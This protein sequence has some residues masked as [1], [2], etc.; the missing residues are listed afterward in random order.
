MGDWMQMVSDIDDIFNFRQLCGLMSICPAIANHHP[1]AASVGPH[2]S[3]DVVSDVESD[4]PVRPAARRRRRASTPPE[5]D[6]AIGTEAEY[7]PPTLPAPPA[8]RRA[9]GRAPSRVPQTVVAEAADVGAAKK[10]KRGGKRK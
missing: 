4:P 8:A 1:P 10:G 5:D 7:D 6:G 3:G 2:P 9:A